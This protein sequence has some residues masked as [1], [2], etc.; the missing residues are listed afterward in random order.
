MDNT[1]VK[2]GTLPTV[3]ITAPSGAQAIVSLY[4]AH[5]LSWKT[6]DGQE[7]LFVSHKSSLD[8][9]RAVRGGV[10]VI[11]P[12]FAAR[13]TGMRHGFARVSTWR[14]GASGSDSAFAQFDLSEA[15]LAP[16]HAAA[17]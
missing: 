8:A 16:A 1:T 17:R 10:P 6:A 13:G 5:L 15:D 4:G 11:F 14:L 2:Y 9:S 12:Q 3:K 7:R